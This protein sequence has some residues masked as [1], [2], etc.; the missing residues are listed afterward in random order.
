LTDSAANQKYIENQKS[1]ILRF[2]LIVLVAGG[3][4]ALGD[5]VF[6]TFRGQSE[7]AASGP[8][9]FRASSGGGAA[10]VSAP[11]RSMLAAARFTAPSKGRAGPDLTQY[12]SRAA[13]EEVLRFYRTEMPRLGWTERE[14]PRGASD[15]EG[16][17]ALWY[18][19]AAGDLCI[20]A[21]STRPAAETA[22]TVLRMPAS[23][24]R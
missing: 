4:L 10:D 13:P 22:V 17:A 2:V 11:P 12:T 18:S 9:Q 1:Q 16:L 20:I 8:I 6:L 21:V 5:Y 23:G 19:N 14:L 24:A 15:R 7:A 3:V